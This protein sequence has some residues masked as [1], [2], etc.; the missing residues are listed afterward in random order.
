MG[1]EQ[2]ELWPGLRSI[3]RLG[4]GEDPR[5][6]TTHGAGGGWGAPP[7][8]AA[9]TGSGSSTLTSLAA[10]PDLTSVSLLYGPP[11]TADV[12]ILA[13]AQTDRRLRHGPSHGLTELVLTNSLVRT[14]AV[15]IALLD[16]CP[17]L[18]KCVQGLP[19]G[20]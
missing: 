11:L 20:H 15:L 16:A 10:L 19:H 9:V 6:T 2:I 13:L 5:L 12:E 7:T 18:R 3:R 14:Q 8:A 17:A 1:I 4:I